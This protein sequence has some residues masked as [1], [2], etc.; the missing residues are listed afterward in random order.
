V[1]IQVI[2]NGYGP[3]VD[4]V[5]KRLP[6]WVGVRNTRKKSVVQ[7]FDASNVAPRDLADYADADFSKGCTIPFL[8]GMALTRYG[9][10]PCGA[11]ASIDRICGWGRG[12]RTLREVTPQQ[13]VAEFSRLCSHCGHFHAR[14]VNAEIMS[15]TWTEAYRRWHHRRPLL[16][17]YPS[18]PL[19][20]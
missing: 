20:R 10:Y 14:K 17:L 2:S 6:D 13:L 9:F 5:L 7:N 19:D 3:H 15:K 11:G 16:P 18:G 4:A 1:I 8:C 12:V